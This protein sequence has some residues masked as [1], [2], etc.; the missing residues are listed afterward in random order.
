MDIERVGICGSGIMGAGVAEVAARAGYEV[1]LRSRT[2]ASADAAVNAIGKSLSR[3]VEKGRMQKEEADEVVAR[4]RPSTNLHELSH[5]QL[6]LESVIEDLPTKKELFEELDLV[7]DDDT[8]L[9][10]NTST[11]PLVE[12]AMATKKPDRVVGVHF[13]NPATVMALV[14]VVEAITT[15]EETVQTALEFA[16][17]CGKQPVR[18]KDRAGFIVNALLFPY[19]NNAVR[20]LESGTASKEDI[21]AAMKA[22]C[23][24]PM[25]P[26]ELLDLVGLDT[27]LAII[28]ALYAEFGDPHY[29]PQ[30]LLRRM[31]AAGQL[32]RK[33]KSGFYTY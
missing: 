3:Q 10:S 22:G 29:V 26:L 33:T 31:V 7:T 6:V 18:V 12:M 27:S 8:V 32:G 4:V 17:Q 19:L 28:E 11:L 23:G 20:L 1:V 25:G 15:S 24:F 9:A 30:P 14:E 16:K 13:F 5:C 2:L 21:D